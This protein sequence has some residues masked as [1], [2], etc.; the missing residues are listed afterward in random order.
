MNKIIDLALNLREAV[1]NFLNPY[2]PWLEFAAALISILLLIGIIYTAL[3]SN[4][5]LYRVDEWADFLGAGDLSRRRT[6]RGW[7][8][9][10]KRLKTDE[11]KNWKIAVLEADKILGE[12][13]RLNGYQGNSVHERLA[14][15]TPE[16]LPNIDELKEVH[17]LRDRIVHEPDFL[18]EQEEAQRIIEVYATAFRELGLID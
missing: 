7:K 8:Q 17:A 5:L 13:L 12:I 3:R 10:L 1:G 6:L 15:V 18:L 4:W 16:I 2:L 14:P 9:I 11:V